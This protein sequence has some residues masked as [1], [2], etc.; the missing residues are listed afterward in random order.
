MN[1][2]RITVKLGKYQIETL[3][4][5]V[6][7]LFSGES[8]QTEFLKSKHRCYTAKAAVSLLKDELS[9]G[10]KAARTRQRRAS[11]AKAVQTK[12]RREAGS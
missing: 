8:A 12:L 7:A 4:G 5:A 10:R 1:N 11:A 6:E 3:I 2:K 9:S